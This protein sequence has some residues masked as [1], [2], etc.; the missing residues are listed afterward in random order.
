M[1]I[2]SNTVIFSGYDYMKLPLNISF[3]GDSSHELF[4]CVEV[5]RPSQPN[6]VM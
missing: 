5:L 4:V 3:L 2:R 6:G 1:V